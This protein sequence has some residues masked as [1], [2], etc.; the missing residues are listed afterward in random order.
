MYE[1]VKYWLF[2]SWSLKQ[3]LSNL[4]G[5]VVAHVSDSIKCIQTSRDSMY[6]LELLYNRFKHWQLVR[7]DLPCLS[8]W[9]TR[10]KMSSN[11]IRLCYIR[12]S[13]KYSTRQWFNESIDQCDCISQSVSR[14]VW[15]APEAAV[16]W[17][18]F[19]CK[20]LAFLLL[21]KFCS[22]LN[23]ATHGFTLETLV[24]EE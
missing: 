8:F 5:T 3:F 11:D 19:S 9:T 24:L 18:L 2:Q 15:A 6:Q 12:S 17:R 7:S 23:N 14:S 13:S 20:Y 10:S 16:E 1:W 21:L 22:L 4:S